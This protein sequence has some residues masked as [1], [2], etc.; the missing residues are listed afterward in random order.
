MTY[1]L[2]FAT[3]SEDKRSGRALTTFFINTDAL[4][5]VTM[6][7]TLCGGDGDRVNTGDVVFYPER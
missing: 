3:M 6:Q 1:N 7:L 4:E 2:F 5:S